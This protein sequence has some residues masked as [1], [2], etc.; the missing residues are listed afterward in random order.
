M[1]KVLSAPYLSLVAETGTEF[2][3]NQEALIR[4]SD[5]FRALLTGPFREA[6][7]ISSHRISSHR[8]D[9]IP[10]LVVKGLEPDF[11]DAARCLSE[12]AEPTITLENALRF[13]VAS[14]QLMMDG[15]T[16]KIAQYLFDNLT[17][18]DCREIATARQ[19]G[20]LHPAL[21]DLLE[22]LLIRYLPAQPEKC[23]AFIAY[24]SETTLVQARGIALSVRFD[25]RFEILTRIAMALKDWHEAYRMVK[26]VWDPLVQKL[27]LIDMAMIRGP[28]PGDGERF[29]DPDREITQ[30]LKSICG[31]QTQEVHRRIAERALELDRRDWIHGL[32]RNDEQLRERHQYGLI[33]QIGVAQKDWGMAGRFA[34]Q[35]GESDSIEAYSFN[36]LVTCVVSAAAEQG[37]LFELRTSV[38]EYMRLFLDRPTPEYEKR[39]EIVMLT[40]CFLAEGIVSEAR[41]G[42]DLLKSLYHLTPGYVWAFEAE[43]AAREGNW[44]LVAQ[45]LHTMFVHCSDRRHPVVRKVV[46]IAI[47]SDQLPAFRRALELGFESK[48]ERQ[49][50]TNLYYKGSILVELALV[51]GD[52]SMAKAEWLKMPIQP[53]S[54][55]DH[56]CI[57][58]NQLRCELGVEQAVLNGEWNE[59]IDLAGKLWRFEADVFLHRVFQLAIEAGNWEVALRA[60]YPHS[61]EWDLSDYHRPTKTV[62]VLTQMGRWSEVLDKMNRL[63]EGG[64]RDALTDYFVEEAVK[65]GQADQVVQAVS[66]HSSSSFNFVLYRLHAAQ[67]KAALSTQNWAEV[68]RHVSALPRLTGFWDVDHSPFPSDAMTQD[69][70]KGLITSGELDA[71]NQVFCL[72]PSSQA[73][74]L[75]LLLDAAI[76]ANNL[77]LSLSVLHR[78]FHL[79]LDVAECKQRLDTL[80]QA[81]GTQ[82]NAFLCMVY[83][84]SDDTAEYELYSAV[85]KVLV[86]RGDRGQ[87]QKVLARLPDTLRKRIQ[88]EL[89]ISCFA[90]CVLL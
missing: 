76:T 8:D 48:F 1:Y 5:Y 81:H 26:L 71:A 78:A 75:F 89:N 27:L 66:A 70:F 61:R 31:N 79:K 36:P 43:V 49:L 57:N 73:S 64:Y 63:S 84:P 77:T 34:I 32:L 80:I 10:R 11:L 45:A 85:A 74:C 12:S 14:R 90:G 7:Q 54:R 6:H 33:V 15:F 4:L 23:A 41:F 50:K 19:R 29:P 17:P 52:G 62:F 38:L 87:A 69:L 35:G 56:Y 86:T 3:F 30:S 59:A 28:H 13:Y 53:R 67:I 24:A 51:Q 58:P 46:E 60:S 55:Y 16:R 20:E 25:R 40:E 22:G 88:T 83:Y 9:S 47:Q 18:D 68:A 65:K 44:G 2:V 82:L 39:S 72:L 42:V 37:G 21:S